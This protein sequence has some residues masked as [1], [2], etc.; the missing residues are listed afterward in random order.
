MKETLDINFKNETYISRFLDKN[1]SWS[2][3]DIGVGPKTEYF[4]LSNVIPKLKVF[5]TEPDPRQF[6]YLKDNF[7]KIRGVLLNYAV[8][9]EP[10]HT[11]EMFLF[12][13]DLKI[14]G[15][16]RKSKLKIDVKITSLDNLDTI[17]EFQKR[18]IL[19]M[20]I[21]G[22]ELKALKSGQNLLKSGRVKF[23]NLEV[24]K[25]KTEFFPTKEEIDIFL[26]NFNYTKLKDYNFHSTHHDTIYKLND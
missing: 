3:Y 9:D 19:W 26:I 11:K 24:R 16:I 14:S 10:I 23:I 12:P 4:S 1:L 5:G 25:E 13:T 18:I 21:E 15:F 7:N 20:D 6:K 2:L 8:S 17:F 22:Y